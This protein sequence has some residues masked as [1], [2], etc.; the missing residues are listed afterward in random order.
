M[1]IDQLT[2]QQIE[3]LVNEK[4]V[5]VTDQLIEIYNYLQQLAKR[6]DQIESATSDNVNIVI[7][8][9][10]SIRIGKEQG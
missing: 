1:T 10:G 8:R 3:D 7:E 9:N 6:L 4:T 5:S 2:R